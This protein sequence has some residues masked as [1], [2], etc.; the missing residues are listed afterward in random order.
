MERTAPLAKKGLDCRFLSEFRVLSAVAWLSF[1]HHHAHGSDK[2]TTSDEKQGSLALERPRMWGL[3]PESLAFWS[4]LSPSPAPTEKGFNFHLVSGW[5]FHLILHAQ[6][7]VGSCRFLSDLRWPP[8]WSQEFLPR[9][10]S[11]AGQP[12]F[13]DNCLAFNV[14]F[15][16][17]ASEGESTWSGAGT[18]KS[19]TQG[20]IIWDYWKGSPIWAACGFPAT[21]VWVACFDS[22]SK[23][24]MCFRFS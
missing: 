16:S 17:C 24:K 11:E 19:K 6:V 22:A 18:I 5:G 3:E 9:Q 12:D 14:G 10:Q 2:V 13:K 7:A 23:V 20:T 21:G 4:H 8:L 15:R 1:L